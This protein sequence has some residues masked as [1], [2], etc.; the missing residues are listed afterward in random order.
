M[1]VFKISR[2]LSSGGSRDIILERLKKAFV[3]D[4]FATDLIKLW[5]ENKRKGQIYIA[6]L[7]MA[8]VGFCLVEQFGLGKTATIRGMFVQESFRGK[9][10][11]TF[12]LRS[13]VQDYGMRDIWVNIS[14][15]AQKFYEKFN[16]EVIQERTDLP[17]DAGRQYL[18][19]R[20]PEGKS[21]EDCIV[22]AGIQI[23]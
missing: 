7:Y 4:E 1:D 17:E 3:D 23:K 12:L 5:E 14:E 21:V 19:C 11:G 16:F 10:I 20:P 18:A 15:G 13:V 9:E 6:Y 22:A 8:P 2:T